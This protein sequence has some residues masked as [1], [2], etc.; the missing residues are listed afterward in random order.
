VIKIIN[1][2]QAK[3]MNNELQNA[4]QLANEMEQSKYTALIAS[5][6]IAE[7]EKLLRPKMYKKEFWDYNKNPDPNLQYDNVVSHF[8]KQI[9]SGGILIAETKPISDFG[10]L[11]DEVGSSKY[12]GLRDDIRTM[13]QMIQPKMCS[14]QQWNNYYDDWQEPKHDEAVKDAIILHKK[15]RS[16]KLEKMSLKIPDSKWQKFMEITNQIISGE[17][18]EKPVL[19]RPNVVKAELELS[20]IQSQHYPPGTQE[21][22]NSFSSRNPMMGKGTELELPEGWGG[23][24]GEPSVPPIQPEA[25]A[26]TVD[27]LPELKNPIVLK[28]TVV[29]FAKLT[30]LKNVQKGCINIQKKFLEEN[31]SNKNSHFVAC[32]VMCFLLGVVVGKLSNKP[33]ENIEL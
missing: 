26:E 5:E 1:K 3:K 29:P 33:N 17:Y 19:P 10:D 2:Q 20:S 25:T 11:I 31:L 30:V 23:G 24:K 21:N 15:Y 28:K 8:A 27:K 7:L 13:N 12:D 4:R 16:E 18:V 32:L 22:Y 9:K 6:N 14:R